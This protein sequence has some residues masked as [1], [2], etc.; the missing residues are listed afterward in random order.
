M[1]NN[2]T[3]PPQLG[4]SQMTDRYKSIRDALEMGPTPG[5]W[6]VLDADSEPHVRA[7]LPENAGHR[8]DDP[9][10]CN[11]Y[12][13]VTPEDSVTFGPWLEAL[14]NAL[15][16]AAFIA[17]CDPDTIA[18]LLAERDAL[19]AEVEAMRKD[20]ERYRRLRAAA[21][22]GHGITAEEFDTEYDASLEEID[23]DMAGKGGAQ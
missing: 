7:R 17:A 11:L 2:R 15:P 20:A 12:D 18:A 22:R 13:D 10:I 6:C 3:T 5:P 1:P 4:A 21:V 9:T 8:W 16:N 14:P 23:A 19:W